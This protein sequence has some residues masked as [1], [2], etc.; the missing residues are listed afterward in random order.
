VTTRVAA[1][2]SPMSSPAAALRS[3]RR[4]TIEARSRLRRTLASEGRG[5]DQ[6]VKRVSKQPQRGC[7]RRGAGCPTRPHPGWWC[8]VAGTGQVG[9]PD[10]ASSSG[11]VSMKIWPF[12]DDR[13]DLWRRVWRR[14]GVTAGPRASSS[15]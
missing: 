2:E 4:S 1:S 6:G 5:T 10:S 12:L 7:R 9:R 3:E 8:S 15:R 11:T 14:L 13:L